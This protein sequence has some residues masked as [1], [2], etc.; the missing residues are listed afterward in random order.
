MKKNHV[1][2]QKYLTYQKHVNQYH[3]QY[4]NSPVL[5]LPTLDE[6]KALTVDDSFWNVGSLTHPSEPSAVDKPTQNGIQ[7]YRTVPSC[8]EELRRIALEVL[9]MVQRS[10][11]TSDKIDSLLPLSKMGV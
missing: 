8:K 2:Q 6:L 1:F 4:P 7:A 5:Q 10:L 3:L 11:T 9:K